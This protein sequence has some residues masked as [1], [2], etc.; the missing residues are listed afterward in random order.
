MILL[1]LLVLGAIV[2]AVIQVCGLTL[3][4]LAYRRSKHWKSKEQE[5]DDILAPPK[6]YDWS[7]ALK[8]WDEDGGLNVEEW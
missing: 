5:I 1:P 2:W 7:Q 6:E 8:D 4:W 3:G